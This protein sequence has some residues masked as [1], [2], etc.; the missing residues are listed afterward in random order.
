MSL[1][2]F[3]STTTSTSLGFSYQEARNS[4][5][6]S[7]RNWREFERQPPAGS[8]GLTPSKPSL[9]TLRENYVDVG[10]TDHSLVSPS[11]S[12]TQREGRPV[13]SL[14]PSRSPPTRPQRYSTRTGGG[15]VGTRHGSTELSPLSPLHSSTRVESG[16]ELR[17]TSTPLRPLLHENGTAGEVPSSTGRNGDVDPAHSVVAPPLTVPL[18]ILDRSDLTDLEASTFEDRAKCNLFEIPAASAASGNSRAPRGSPGDKNPTTPGGHSG[19]NVPPKDAA[20]HLCEGS[21]A[22]LCEGSDADDY[23]H[24]SPH[25]TS[26]AVQTLAA[27]SNRNNNV[28]YNFFPRPS[29]T[30]TRRSKEQPP[31]ISH[32]GPPNTGNRGGKTNYYGDGD[33]DEALN[34]LNDSASS[35]RSGSSDPQSPVPNQ[36]SPPGDTDND[37]GLPPPVP[38]KLRRRKSASPP[39]TLPNGLRSSI[40]PSS[41][42]SSASD[43]GGGGGN[44]PKN[45]RHPPEFATGPAN[46][47]ECSDLSQEE[48]YEDA[49]SSI[50]TATLVPSELGEPISLHSI[51]HLTVAPDQS[52]PQQTKFNQ[53]NGGR[54][55]TA[56]VASKRVP[57]GAY[58]HPETFTHHSLSRQSW[59]QQQQWRESGAKSVAH[60]PP[61]LP[62]NHHRQQPP[63]MSSYTR[64]TPIEEHHHNPKKRQTLI[65]VSTSSG[66]DSSLRG[67][68]PPHKISQAVVQ[69]HAYSQSSY[70][71]PDDS[72]S[73][74]QPLPTRPILPHTFP[75]APRGPNFG[76]I[77]GASKRRHPQ[78]PHVVRNPPNRGGGGGNVISRNHRLYHSHRSGLGSPRFSHAQRPSDDAT[79]MRRTLSPPNT[80][81]RL[82]QDGDPLGA[83]YYRPPGLVGGQ[84]TARILHRGGVDMTSPL[85]RLDKPNTP[86]HNGHVHSQTH[87]HPSQA[88]HNTRTM[89]A[90]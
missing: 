31:R 56:D 6:E 61:P 8:T 34:D 71:Y 88:A 40:S 19:E 42:S 76:L 77:A 60:H 80:S 54:G 72:L 10:Y 28:R 24:L 58:V 12:L 85:V 62:Y 14:P 50:S 35:S 90:V 57:A 78:V 29:Q 7:R 64:E 87:T 21:D 15:D 27:A 79:G 46:V 25:F 59:D 73:L 1:L 86:T 81:R 17:H 13:A 26:G 63:P 33:I 23:D 75:A 38:P 41:C 4:V 36:Y 37:G 39:T 32:G 74:S 65:S 44:R 43:G 22:H 11:S 3:E 82:P 30:K 70:Y 52:R 18:L 68:S 67:V 16:Y 20:A 47:V 55:T 48:A 84:R 89:T 5:N 2:S 66:S 53:T 49:I 51:Q 9:T 69:T 83:K 45:S